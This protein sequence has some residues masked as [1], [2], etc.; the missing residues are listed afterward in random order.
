MS[1]RSHGDGAS[2][3]SPLAKWRSA[4][5]MSPARV[6]V[7]ASATSS[8][9]RFIQY[10][11][12]PEDRIRPAR[13]PRRYRRRSAAAPTAPGTPWV[14]SLLAL[15]E[16][17][18]GVEMGERRRQIALHQVG[19]G[20]APAEC[21]RLGVEIGV[22]KRFADQHLHLVA[23]ATLSVCCGPPQQGAG[24]HQP[25][26]EQASGLLGPLGDRHQLVRSPPRRGQASDV[27]VH[28]GGQR[29]R[30]RR[31]RQVAY[32]DEACAVVDLET[33]DRCPLVQCTDAQQ[34]QVVPS[35]RL[36]GAVEER[37]G[38]AE[39]VQPCATAED[40]QGLAGDLAQ[41]VISAESRAASARISAWA[42]FRVPSHLGGKDVGPTP[43]DRLIEHSHVL[44]LLV[45]VSQ[46]SAATAAL[47]N[48]T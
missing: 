39:V 48:R 33:V 23:L 27:D 15:D 14:R 2:A 34:W 17:D 10:T 44:Q 4:S 9:A 32:L 16:V 31:D 45:A 26:P 43:H 35:G 40:R 22:P 3:S 11:V 36:N 6:A 21:H 30:A 8:H 13:P 46:R 18:G 20:A 29:R 1:W 19:N 38:P 41:I 12:A 7:T 5:E 42:A 47:A 24:Q 37:P 25:Q 28:A